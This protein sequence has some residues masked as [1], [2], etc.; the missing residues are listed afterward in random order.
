M[1]MKTIVKRH[2]IPVRTAIIKK[3]KINTGEDMKKRE[4]L[5]NSGD[6]ANWYSHYRKQD[7]DSSKILK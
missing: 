1:Q 3:I 5:S 7:E 2:L 4:P 6:N